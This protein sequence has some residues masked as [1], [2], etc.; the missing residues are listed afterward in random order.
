MINRLITKV[1]VAIRKSYE[2]F[3][4]KPCSLEDKFCC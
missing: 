2:D 3:D 4:A 1:I